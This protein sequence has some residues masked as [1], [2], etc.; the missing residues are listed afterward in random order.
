MPPVE[1]SEW[2]PAYDAAALL[3][4]E[5]IV[6]YTEAGV[7]LPTRRYV[8]PGIVPAYDDTQLTVAVQQVS[9]GQ[10][11]RAIGVP[12]AN[13]GPLLLVSLRVELIRCTPKVDD[14]GTPPTV[15]AMASSAQEVLRDLALVHKIVREAAP[16][17]A[18]KGD[19]MLG[20]GI[21][22]A[23]TGASPLGPDGG[24]AGTRLDVDVPL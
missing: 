22:V 20:R 24:L 1:P 9:V 2:G 5:L 21:P 19:P 12:V 17:L 8:V 16:T 10:P 15:E 4:A 13:C 7:P 14:R 6:G 11:G 3:L 23:L 18:G